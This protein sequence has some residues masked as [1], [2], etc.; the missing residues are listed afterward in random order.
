MK[1]LLFYERL[2]PGLSFQ[3]YTAKVFSLDVSPQISYRV[4]KYASMGLGWVYRVGFDKE[5]DY[6]VS[7][8]GLSGFR[9][10]VN[11]RL[12]KGLSLYGEA[13]RMTFRSVSKLSDQSGTT[14]VYNMNI[15]LGK[16]Y[17]VSPKIYGSILALYR[18]EFGDHAP[19]TTK[20]NLRM[21]FEYRFKRKPQAE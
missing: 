19:G 7:N 17:K 10:F 9:G 20:F 21:V 6:F 15:G 3:P 11:Y 14:A 8:Q 4:T 16:R 2:Q 5:Y 13:E 12:V 18:I 1:K